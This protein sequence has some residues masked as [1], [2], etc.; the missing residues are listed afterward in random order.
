[1]EIIRFLFLR[2]KSVE[3][4]NVRYK[5]FF[6]K[7]NKLFAILKENTQNILKL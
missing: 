2:R 4:L 7:S 6:Q 1:M 3:K 5:I